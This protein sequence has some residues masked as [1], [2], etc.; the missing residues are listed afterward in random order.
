M[1]TLCIDVGLRNLSM[2]IM[3]NTFNNNYDIL[4]WDVFNV[5][6]SD[7]YRCQSKFKNGKLCNRKCTMKYTDDNEEIFCC[8]THFPKNLLLPSK[9]QKTNTSVNTSSTTKP[10][11]SS[12]KSKKNTSTTHEFKKKSVDEYLLQDIAKAFIQRVQDIYDQTIELFKQIDTILIELQPKCNPKMLFTSHILYGKLVE[13]YSTNVQFPNV[14]TPTIKFVRASQKLKAY[15][16]PAIECH[17]KG[18]YAKR[19]WLSVKYG[20]WFLENKFSKEQQDIWLPTLTSDKTK[21]L[22]DRMDCFLM[23]INS[24]T[25]IP[26]NNKKT[27]QSAKN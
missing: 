18:A 3:K 7:D 6:D 25:G 8:K 16:G 10:K 27:K 12:K 14:T 19:K 24:L 17:L 9:E 20:F 22:D 1:I 4:L 15:T 21:K 26:N 23:A 11:T 13:L 5:L 2:C